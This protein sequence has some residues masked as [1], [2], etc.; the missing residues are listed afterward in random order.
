MDGGD[1]DAGLFRS[2]FGQFSI[3]NYAYGDIVMRFFPMYLTF[4]L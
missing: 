2:L 3:Y 1:R 4:G